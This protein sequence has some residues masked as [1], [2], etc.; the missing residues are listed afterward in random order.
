MNQ[1][2][3]NYENNFILSFSFFFYIVGKEV[4]TYLALQKSRIFNRLHRRLEINPLYS[5]TIS[6]KSQ[7]NSVISGVVSICMNRFHNVFHLKL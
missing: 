7:R 4:E 5:Y 1:N 6:V 2:D 3:A